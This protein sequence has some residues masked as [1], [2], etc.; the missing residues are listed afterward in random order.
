MRRLRLLVTLL[1][2]S[3]V[4]SVPAP[5]LADDASPSPSAPASPSP[6]PSPSPSTSLSPS[7]SPSASSD[8]ITLAGY[9]DPAV[10]PDEGDTTL[11]VRAMNWLGTPAEC[12][13]FEGIPQDYP[14]WVAC[15]IPTDQKS[16][17]YRVGIQ[18]CM[19][20]IGPGGTTPYKDSASIRA[21]LGKDGYLGGTAIA[22]RRRARAAAG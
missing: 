21:V 20:L 8:V 19:C 3:P 10:V 4:L 6:T 11:V 9:F 14:Y 22:V 15:P 7:A 13:L 16:I 17:T 12:S 2:S 18:P 5:A 1:L